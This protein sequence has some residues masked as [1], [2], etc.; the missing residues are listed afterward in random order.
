MTV[1]FD[2]FSYRYL[3]MVATNT[4]VPSYPYFGGT[5]PRTSTMPEETNA[6]FAA[7][8]GYSS[9]NGSL[10]S[11][12]PNYAVLGGTLLKSAH[13]PPTTN[14][15]NTFS[16]ITGIPK[17]AESGIWKYENGIISPEWINEAAENYAQVEATVVY[18]QDT[19]AIVG[20]QVA[21]EAAYGPSTKIVSDSTCR[22]GF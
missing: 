20:D 4:A 14:V 12:S 19:I 15:G 18:L 8:V 16:S 13:N 1:S 21:F 2:A 22:M 3:S 7:I 11:G 10:V 9:S 17:G 5:I 6:C